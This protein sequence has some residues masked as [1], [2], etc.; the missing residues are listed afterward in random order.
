MKQAMPSGSISIFLTTLFKWF[1][2]LKLDVRQK[3]RK[4]LRQK[5]V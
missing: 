2:V 4:V 1:S 5:L 3:F